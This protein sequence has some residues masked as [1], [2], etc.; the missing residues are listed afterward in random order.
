MKKKVI[1]A[2]A[3]LIIL[4]IGYYFAVLYNP[5]ADVPEE[6][7]KESI[8]IFKASPDEITKISIKNEFDSYTFI[9]SNDEWKLEGKNIEILKDR[10][11]SLKYTVSGIS[12]ADIIE[13][14]AEDLAIYGL[15]SPLAE[16]AFTAGTERVFTMGS[17]APT[18][19][20]YYFAEGRKVYTIG[21]ST[22]DI[23]RKTLNDYRS[24]TVVSVKTED[25]RGIKITGTGENI[26]V[27]Y[28]PMP[29]G[30]ADE[31]G[32]LSVWKMTS[33]ITYS[34]ANEKFMEKILEPACNITAES[35]AE[36]FPS[37]LSKYNLNK[38]FSIVLEDKTLTYRVGSAGGVNYVYPE[39][40]TMVY[41]VSAAKLA[42]LDV[43]AID[44]IERFLVFEFLDDV[45]AIEID[46][47]KAKGTLT[48]KRGNNE[49]YYLDNDIF[50]EEGAFKSMFQAII[51]LTADGFMTKGYDKTTV[52]GTITYRLT[53][54]SVRTAR[55]YPYDD[56]NVAA[57]VDGNAIFYMK[58]TR[59]S[60]LEGYLN[61]LRK[62]PSERV[63]PR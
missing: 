3:V 18:G 54:G 22:G 19:N 25:V 53:N 30:R 32:T 44:I 24:M 8:V 13:E 1:T 23:F 17:L 60:D 5:P 11:N 58:K 61:S 62:N 41:A 39:G 45:N 29:E 52:L 46:T 34:V 36:D 40:G 35:I 59:L 57:E 33:P 49:T 26:E 47:P 16:L 63:M 51:G 12:A 56:I 50:L 48:V 38:K 10:V 15:D 6:P 2:V 7:A 28:A 55:F 37:N 42:F 14:N 27:S 31:Y 21:K 9:K 4:G 43:K 20:Y